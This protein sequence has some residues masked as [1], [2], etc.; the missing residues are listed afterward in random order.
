[1]RSNSS[2]AEV[3]KP[4]EEDRDQR[5]RPRRSRPRSRRAGRSPCAPAPSLLQQL[6]IVA[7]DTIRASTPA[8]PR[9]ATL[10][11]LATSSSF[12]A[13]FMPAPSVNGTR[14]GKR[15]RAATPDAAPLAQRRTRQ[16][17]TGRSRIRWGRPLR[18]RPR[19][20]AGGEPCWHARPDRAGARPGGPRGREPRDRRDDTGARRPRRSTSS[21]RRRARSPRC[22]AG[23]VD[24][25]S[26]ANNHGLDYGEAASAT[27]SR[28]PKR[29]RFPVVGIGLNAKQAYRRTADDQRAA[30]RGHR[31][32]TGARR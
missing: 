9:L 32:D 21:A 27:R 16:R 1:M 15:L 13:P 14:A 19:V 31:G 4:L 28:R 18:G 11:L 22:A 26:M 7:A 5:E 2:D 23:G 12:S 24:V 30:D 25:V 20:E 6:A 3:R 17:Q 8:H 29:Y 10:K